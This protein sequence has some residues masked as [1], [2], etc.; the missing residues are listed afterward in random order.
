[1]PSLE[2]IHQSETIEE[3]RKRQTDQE[4]NTIKKIDDKEAA[5]IEAEIEHQRIKSIETQR[6]KQF[7]RTE[8]R[9]DFFCEYILLHNIWKGVQKYESCIRNNKRNYR[10]RRTQ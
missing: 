2:E 9:S 5:E 4:W 7:E 3:Q 1:M 8:S 10:K 6:Q